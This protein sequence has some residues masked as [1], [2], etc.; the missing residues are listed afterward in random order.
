MKIYLNIYMVCF[1]IIIVKYGCG[2]IIWKYVLNIYIFF[3]GKENFIG[4]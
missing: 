1:F 3:I 4:I 2:K